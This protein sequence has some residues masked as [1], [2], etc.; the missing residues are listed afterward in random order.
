MK[1]R[2]EARRDAIV[3]AAAQL[4]EEAGYER[5]SMNE[6]AKRLGGSKTTLYGYFPSKESLFEAVV[7]SHA[8]GHLADATAGLE[9]MAAGNAAELGDTLLRFGERMLAV[10]AH[11]ARAM[12]VYRMVIAEAGRSELGRLFYQSGPAESLATLG[13]FLHAAMQAGL[14]RESDPELRAKQFLALVTA[15][16]EERMYQCNPAP[17][18][19]EQ[20]R[21]MVKR[22]VDMFLAGA[23]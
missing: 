6:L 7:R 3:E 11:D 10:L 9:G 4:F 19:S 14:L 5:A 1:T 21:G 23:A 16:I 20:V 17:L 15:E 13:G 22:A 8:T 2:T 18:S 12:A